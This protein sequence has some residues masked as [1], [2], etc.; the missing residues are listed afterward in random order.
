MSEAFLGEIRM[1]GFDFPPRDWAFCNG[2]LLSIAQNQALYAL[3]GTRFGG[4]GVSDFALPN[5]Q[6]RVPVHTGNGVALGQ[7]GGAETVTL[8]NAE[9]PE[10]THNARAASSNAEVDSPA[11]SIP[12]T[13][14]IDAYHGPTNLTPLAHAVTPTGGGGAHEN[15]QPSLAVGFCIALAGIWPSRS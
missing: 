12:A 10:H 2:Q 9:M 4:N 13:A 8:T 3:L 5:F 15:R 1:V 11:G 14:T 7:A 6:G